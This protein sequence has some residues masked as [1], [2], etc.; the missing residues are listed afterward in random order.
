MN[1]V[2][3]RQFTNSVPHALHQK[4]KLKGLPVKRERDNRADKH[5]GS[6]RQCL[7]EDPARYLFFFEQTSDMKQSKS[8]K[9]L[10]FHYDWNINRSDKVRLLRLLTITYCLW[11]ELKHYNLLIQIAVCKKTM[12]KMKFYKA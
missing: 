4:A 1:C 2:I 8:F 7:F 9:W 11:G 6:L 10:Y 5:G 3:L 12:E